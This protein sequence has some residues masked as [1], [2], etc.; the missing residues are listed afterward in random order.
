[1]EIIIIIIVIVVI[2]VIITCHFKCISH[3]CVVLCAMAAWVE[4]WLLLLFIC[5]DELQDYLSVYQITET[6]F[7]RSE[8]QCFC[9]F[10][11]TLKVEH[12]NKKKKKK[13]PTDAFVFCDAA[14]AAVQ[15]V[16]QRSHPGRPGPS[17]DAGPDLQ[18]ALHQKHWGHNGLAHR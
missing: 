17:E 11:L 1:M 13:L 16:F 2:I 5:C 14:A 15:V 18:G 7:P 10:F 4:V 8:C 9:L 6:R 12:P 3:L